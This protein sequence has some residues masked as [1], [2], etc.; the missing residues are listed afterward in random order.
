[1]YRI[2]LA[3]RLVGGQPRGYCREIELP[4]VPTVG[5]RFEQ[6]TSTTLW[7]TMSGGE[8]SPVVEEVTYDLDEEIFVCLFSVGS[9]LAASFWTALPELQPGHVCGVMSYFRHKIASSVG[10]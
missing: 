5:M 2:L 9:P 6:G 10:S 1:M 8:F 7:E 4:F 3:V